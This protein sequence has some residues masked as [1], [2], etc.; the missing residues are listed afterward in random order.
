MYEK[1]E[2]IRIGYWKIRGLA[3]PIRYILAYCEHPWEEDVYEQGN[4]PNFSI[5]QWTN[6]KNTLNLPFPNMPYMIA[7]ECNLTDVHAIMIY[8]ATKFCDEVVPQTAEDKAR[9]DQLYS[10]M[11]EVKSAITGPCY[12]GTEKVQLKEQVKE[13][14]APL[15]TTLGKKDYL[16]GDSLTYIDFIFLEL[17]EFADYLTEDFINNNKNIAKYVKKVKGNKQLKKYFA[18]TKY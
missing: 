6:K 9:A 4:A 15:V 5:E 12:V 14:M 8:I 2:P 16:V 18:S 13:K 11:K 7:E 1:N 17:C 3:Q 10:L